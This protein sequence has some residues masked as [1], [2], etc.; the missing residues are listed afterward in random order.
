M[1]NTTPEYIDGTQLVRPPEAWAI[2]REQRQHLEALQRWGER[3]IIKIAWTPKDYRDGRVPRSYYDQP[4][5]T[6]DV[7]QRIA[8]VY[9]TSG[10]TKGEDYGVGFEGGFRPESYISYLLGADERED[11]RTTR[12][13]IFQSDNFQAQLPHLPEVR[14]GDVVIQILSWDEDGLPFE[15]GNRYAIGSVVRKTLRTG[16]HRRNDKAVI[17]TSHQVSLIRIPDSDPRYK[18]PVV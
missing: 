14:T 1:S 7:Q 16:L 18:L 3:V 9:K 15:L 4:G 17:L 2:H 10:D 6:I 11:D 5:E 12:T 8:E 13:G